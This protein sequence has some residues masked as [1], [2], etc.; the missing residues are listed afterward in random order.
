[1]KR[2]EVTRYARALLSWS[3]DYAASHA[4]R[5]YEKFE[6]LGDEERA[7]TWRKVETRILA[8]SKVQTAQGITIKPMENSHEHAA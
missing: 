8:W 7:S 3:P 5:R 6:A 2:D 4:A 1:M